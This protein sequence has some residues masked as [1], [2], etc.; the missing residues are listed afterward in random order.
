VRVGC[1]LH[2]L[3]VPRLRGDDGAGCRGDGAERHRHPGAASSGTRD[4]LGGCGLVALCTAWEFPACAGMTVRVV[5]VTVRVVGVTVP[6]GT[7][8]PGPRVAEPGISLGG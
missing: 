8:I 2:G 6:K 5:G 7:V 4:L 3:G 1:A